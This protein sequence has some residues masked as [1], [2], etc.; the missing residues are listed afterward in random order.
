VDGLR[1]VLEDAQRVGFVGPGPVEVQLAH[2]E[3]LAVLIERSA[4]PVQG[5]WLDLGAGGGLPG[6]VLAI[7]WTRATGALLEA[8]ARRCAFL[9]DA[10][11]RL[12]LVGRAAV[13]EG[14]AEDVARSPEHRGRYELVVARS[15]G[16]PAVTA[17]CA[18]GFLAATGRLIVSE[19]PA[20]DT[21]ETA[22]LGRWPS[23]ELDTL[24]LGPAQML[25]GAGATVAVMPRNGKVVDD[26][27]PR[28][29]GI[30]GKR[31]RWRA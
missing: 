2:A 29:S 12:G 15:F 5:P 4:A 11:D 25:G 20:T 22:V 31:P 17:E 24:G 6:L 1:A 26:R 18:V 9:R 30:P 27:W 19:P 21:Q 7:R 13:V 23:I 3:S 14:R 8:N 16:P 28:R 10:L